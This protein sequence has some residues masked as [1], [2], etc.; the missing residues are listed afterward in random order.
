MSRNT[1]DQRYQVKQYVGLVINSRGCP[2]LV[3][4]TGD[5][6]FYLFCQCYPETTTQT[7]LNNAVKKTDLQDDVKRALRRGNSYDARGVA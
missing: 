1:M 2:W 4:E 5:P 7:G 3:F 6:K